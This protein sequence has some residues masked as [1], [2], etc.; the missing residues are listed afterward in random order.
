MVNLA[1]VILQT[2]RVNIYALERSYCWNQYNTFYAEFPFQATAQLKQAFKDPAVIPALCAVMTGST[3][4][5][6]GSR[7]SQLLSL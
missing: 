5:Q 4:P 6:V 7:R 1:V 2:P 3:N